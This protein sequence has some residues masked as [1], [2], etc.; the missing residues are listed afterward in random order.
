MHLC[1]S[2]LGER[3]ERG[4]GRGKERERDREREREKERSGG[5]SAGLILTIF[6]CLTDTLVILTTPYL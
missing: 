5:R 1:S 3:K 6:T 2:C 4:V